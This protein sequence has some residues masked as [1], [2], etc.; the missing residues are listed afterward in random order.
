MFH[1]HEWQLDDVLAWDAR[2]RKENGGAPAAESYYQAQLA[3]SVLSGRVAP[4]DPLPDEHHVLAFR[5][6]MMLGWL[7][8]V[9]DN[10]SET[11]QR[12]QF[13]TRIEGSHRISLW[14][15]VWLARAILLLG[16]PLAALRV[17][18][19]G[20]NRVEQFGLTFLTGPLVWTGCAAASIL[21]DQ[22]M[23]RNYSQRAGLIH[24]AFNIQR[25][26]SLMAQ[27]DASMLLGDVNAGVRAGNELAK[28]QSKVDFSQPGFWPWEDSYARLLIAS[29]D[30]NMAE[31]V[32]AAAEDRGCSSDIASVH[33]RIAGPRASLFIQQGDIASGLT[34]LDDAVDMLRPLQ[35]PYY[36]ARL[37]FSLGQALRRVG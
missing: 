37:L 21:G 16:E 34:V 24:D 6:E 4:F 28:L 10:P 8:L 3:E 7:S 36:E 11:R 17:V 26:T 15:D 1:L 29:G 30:T 20:L 25:I 32:V 12:L 27:M 2:A 19:R 35:V 22:A 9:H 18:E 13:T 5:R 31:Q 33:A 14:M 23:A